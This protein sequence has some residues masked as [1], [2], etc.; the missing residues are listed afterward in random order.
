MVMGLKSRIGMVG[1]KYQRA[2]LLPC[3]LFLRKF[4]ERI[5]DYV[6]GVLALRL[7]IRSIL[8]LVVNLDGSKTLVGRPCEL[9]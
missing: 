4:Y 1:I 9:Q 5:L 6:I 7:V 8:D 2:L 3:L